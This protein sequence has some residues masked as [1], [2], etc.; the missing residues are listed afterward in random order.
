MRCEVADESVVVMK[1]RPEKAGNSLEGKTGM[2]RRLVD[3]G[4]YVPKAVA[5]C[6]G[7]KFIRRSLEVA[8]ERQA[9][10]KPLDG[11][12]HAISGRL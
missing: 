1:S 6:E 12:G 10:H 9:G 3:G 11:A 5:E 2:T 7:R 8:L 4:R